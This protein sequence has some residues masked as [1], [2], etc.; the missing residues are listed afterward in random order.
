MKRGMIYLLLAV[1]AASLIMGGITLYL[2]LSD[3]PV[4]VEIESEPLSKT[5]WREADDDR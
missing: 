5:S 4:P 3:P 1:P 2:A